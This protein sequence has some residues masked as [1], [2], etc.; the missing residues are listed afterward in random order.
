LFSQSTTA[1]ILGTVTDQTGAVLAGATVKVTSLATGE[2]RTVNSNDPWRLCGQLAVPAHYKV[3]VILRG[4]KTFSVPNILAAAGDRARVDASLVTGEVTETVEV[5]AATPLLQT[6]SSTL[7]N[8]GGGEVGADLP[9]NGRNFIQ[10][11]QLTVGANEGMPGGMTSGSAPD[12]RRQTSSISA[13]GQSELL[14]N[15]MIDG[16]DNNERIIGGIGIRPSVEAISEY[17]VQTSD[18]S[19]SRDARQEP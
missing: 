19:P 6:D 12:D 15:E 1:D 2:V 5:E 7:G 18:Y 16:A 14:N 8:D 4:F 9:L 13:N 17:R 11:A 3:E 10:L